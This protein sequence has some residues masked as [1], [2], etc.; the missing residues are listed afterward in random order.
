MWDAGM[1]FVVLLIA[2]RENSGGWKEE[3]AV[4]GVV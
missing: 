1:G 4:I 2:A 3:A